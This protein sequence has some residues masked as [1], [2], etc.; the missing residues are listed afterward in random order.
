MLR[1]KRC[2]GF[3]LYEMCIAIGILAFAAAVS[4]PVFRDLRTQ[5]RN[6]KAQGAVALLRSAILQYS[7]KEIAAGRASRRYA[8]G[9]NAGY[10]VTCQIVD[11]KWLTPCSAPHI[12]PN[13]D[14]PENPWAVAAG[15][16]RPDDVYA[17]D[18]FPKGTICALTQ[19]GWFYNNLNGDIWAS[20]NVNGEC[21]F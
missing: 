15:K 21:R 14:T 2:G 10:P 1:K 19:A 18:G 20:T 9:Q 11:G 16:T 13:Q 17:C 8:T 5:A 4:I 6:A 3:N 7:A 12:L